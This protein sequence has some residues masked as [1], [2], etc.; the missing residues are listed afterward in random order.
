MKK[1]IIILFVCLIRTEDFES[2][3]VFTVNAN[4]SESISMS[5]ATSAWING[6]S[7]ISSNPAGI[8]GLNNT[9]SFDISN[10]FETSHVGDDYQDTQ[11]PYFAIG[12]GTKGREKDEYDL[13][14][15]DL[16]SSYHGPKY[17]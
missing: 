15:E 10:S 1:I 2:S 4:S 12:W 16:E 7:S 5:G 9:I 3:G 17:Y 6:I 14:E 13:A 8:A 11:Y